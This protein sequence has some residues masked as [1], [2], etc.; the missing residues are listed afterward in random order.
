MLHLQ[1]LKF[2]K[3][4]S[5]NKWSKWKKSLRTGKKKEQ[6]GLYPINELTSH[7]KWAATVHFRLLPLC[8]SRS[9][10]LTLPNFLRE[11]G[12][13]DLM[14]NPLC[15]NNDY[16]WRAKHGYRILVWIFRLQKA[17]W[18]SSH[19]NEMQQCRLRSPKD[20]S[21]NKKPRRTDFTFLSICWTSLWRET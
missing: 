15:L 13:F 11:V 10:R 3:H 16:E 6:W 4:W 18:I 14:P 5:T 17:S 1:K 7:L 2:E 8:S 19:L 20:T 12:K 9:P 21:N